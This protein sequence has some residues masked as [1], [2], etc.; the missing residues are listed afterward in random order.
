MNKLIKV[1]YLFTFDLV[2]ELIQTFGKE[3]TAK[4]ATSGPPSVCFTT[5][6]VSIKYFQVKLGILLYDLN[7]KYIFSYMYLP[8]RVWADSLYLYTMILT[9]LPWMFHDSEKHNVGDRLKKILSARLMRQSFLLLVNLCIHYFSFISLIS[10]CIFKKRKVY[11][12][13]HSQ[14]RNLPFLLNL[15]FAGDS[16][17]SSVEASTDVSDVQLFTE[18]FYAVVT[19][20]MRAT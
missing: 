7:R 19:S 5:Q 12:H 10:F 15:I 18:S 8:Q 16:N 17:F 13:E 2:Q 4:S 3:K 14:I 1:S 20:I 11:L 9:S 6:V